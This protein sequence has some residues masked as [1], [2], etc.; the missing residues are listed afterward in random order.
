MQHCIL[1]QIEQQDRGQVRIHLLPAAAFF[2]Q[3]HRYAPVFG[4]V[5][6]VGQYLFQQGVHLHRF[7]F[8]KLS[9]F[10]FG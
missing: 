6:K 10:D 5:G 2:F 1:Y 7:L 4:L 3:G 9:V 8:P